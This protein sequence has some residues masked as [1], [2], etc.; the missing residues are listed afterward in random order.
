MEKSCINYPYF[1]LSDTL[2]K[3]I[4]GHASNTFYF[5]LIISSVSST[6]LS[7]LNSL[8]FLTKSSNFFSPIKLLL[9]IFSC[10][11]LFIYSNNTSLPCCLVF[12]IIARY[13]VNDRYGYVA[14]I[15][16]YIYWEIAPISFKVLLRILLYLGW[17]LI[18][19]CI[20]L[21]YNYLNI[22]AFTFLKCSL[23]VCM[24]FKKDY[25]FV[26]YALLWRPH[27]T[28]PSCLVHLLSISF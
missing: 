20:W 11:N 12:I 24:I 13:Y 7:F 6:S 25:Q 27:F 10:L 28:I 4:V 15:G 9:M 22:I 5:I 1:L 17:S 16:L 23:P 19:F 14:C 8:I 26:Y 18:I 2:M 3:T 21:G